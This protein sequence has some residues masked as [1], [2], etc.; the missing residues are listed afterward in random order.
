M[1][2]YTPST[3]FKKIIEEFEKDPIKFEKPKRKQ[4][5]PKKEK[6]KDEPKKPT[7][8]YFRYQSDVRSRAKDENPGLDSRSI[9]KIVGQMWKD[10]DEEH[11]D[12]YKEEYQ[13]DL[14]IY[15]KEMEKYCEKKHL[16]SAF[17]NC[18]GLRFGVL[19]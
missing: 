4:K 6:D 10:E 16:H 3:E 18:H 8:A 2:N 9:S 14:K 17:D 12:H 19:Q 7:P 11:R 15:K 5:N 1:D 13:N